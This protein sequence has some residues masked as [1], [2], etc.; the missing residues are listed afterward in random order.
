M[1]EAADVL[2][3]WARHS[4]HRLDEVDSTQNVARRLAGEGAPE[5]TV[6][7]AEHQTHGRGRFRRRWVDEASAG[8][9]VSIVLRPTGPASALPQ[10]P[11]VAGV[12]TAQAIEE[13]SGLLVR[14]AW[15]NDLLIEGRK[16]AGILAESVVPPGAGTFV[17][18][19]IGINVN[20]TR[21]PAE[22]GGRA[23][24]LALEAGRAFDREALLTGMLSRLEQWYRRWLAEGFGPAAGA[25]RRRSM[26]LGR[27]VSAEGRVQGTAVDLA[28]DGALLVRTEAGEIVRL[29]AG[30]VR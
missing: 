23:T 11:L 21:F 9:L 27:Q 13:A 29:V 16:V 6:V 7:W 19:G 4:P 30:E 5:G 8:L 22:L 26:T 1:I 25:W 20:Q 12:A 10:L 28:A 15:P 14:L 3:G 17:I 2:R 24:S 18:L